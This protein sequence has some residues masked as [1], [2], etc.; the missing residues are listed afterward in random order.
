VNYIEELKYNETKRA[1]QL[2]A[3]LEETQKAL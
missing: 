2:E 1:V 3:E